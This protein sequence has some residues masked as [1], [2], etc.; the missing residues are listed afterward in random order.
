VNARD[1]VVDALRHQAAA[2]AYLESPFYDALLTNMAADAARGGPTCGLLEPYASNLVDDA[3]ALRVMGGLHFRVLRGDEPTLAA[4]YPSTGGDGDADAAWPAFR[5]LLDDPPPELVDAL[6]RPP[7]TNEVGRSASLV[8]GFLA[9]AA[10]FGLPLR[11]LELGASAGLN[12]QFDRYRY[13][14]GAAGFGPGDSPVRFTDLWAE[15]TPPF[16]TSLVVAER[17]GCDRDPIDVSVADD[18]L[19]LLAYI[20]PDV[21]ARFARTRAALELAAESPPP[22]DRADAAAWIAQQLPVPTRSRAT[23][24]FHSIVWQY[25]DTATA[26]G[27]RTAIETAGAAATRDAPVAWLRLEPDDTWRA[28]GRPPPSHAQLRLRVWPGGDDRHLAD[29]SFHTGPLSPPAHG[30]SGDGP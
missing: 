2:C 22:V 23:V 8:A 13:E 25:L 24:A 11:V 3:S 1:A 19:R 16:A 20:W 14:Q 27:V 5:A 10:E 28:E 4:H 17:R 9:V 21:T 18:R 15:V 30:A 12:L 7:Q 29:A 26:A 6:R